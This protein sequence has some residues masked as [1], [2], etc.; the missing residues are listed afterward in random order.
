MQFLS[1]ITLQHFFMN[2][3]PCPNSCGQIVARKRAKTDECYAN[4]FEYVHVFTEINKLKRIISEA[5]A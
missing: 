1:Q 3:H 4:K 2:R 5:L